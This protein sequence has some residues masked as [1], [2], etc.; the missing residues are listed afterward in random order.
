LSAKND[1]KCACEGIGT[2]LN[3]F[4]LIDNN[5]DMTGARWNN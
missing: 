1:F 3:L 2:Q 5:V 4:E